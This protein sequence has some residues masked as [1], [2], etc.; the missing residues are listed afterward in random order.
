M[1]FPDA[2]GVGASRTHASAGHDRSVAGGRP[3]GLV[4]TLAGV[5]A[6]RADESGDDGRQLRQ[7]APWRPTRR[8]QTLATW[9]AE[10]DHGPRPSSRR[11]WGPRRSRARQDSPDP[12]RAAGGRRSR[13][14]GCGNADAETRTSAVCGRPRPGPAGLAKSDP[15]PSPGP[16]LIADVPLLLSLVQVGVSGSPVLE[17]RDG[18]GPQPRRPGRRLAQPARRPAD[19]PGRRT[20]GGSRDWTWA[21]RLPQPTRF[22]AA[23][24]RPGSGSGPP[25]RCGSE[26]PS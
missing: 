15:G 16:P 9:R 17:R 1:T 7:R 5:P 23:G 6:L 18:S 3:D 25:T 14:P 20:G 10:T 26:W 11:A 2:P 4:A 24:H 8:A 13:W 22:R 21:A 12:A 19:D